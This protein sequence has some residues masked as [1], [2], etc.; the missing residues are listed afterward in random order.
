MVQPWGPVKVAY[1]RLSEISWQKQFLLLVGD[2]EM[3]VLSLNTVGHKTCYKLKRLNAFRD[4]YL[5]S[6]NDL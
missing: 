6:L 1:S 5:F 3:E 2:Q 4:N